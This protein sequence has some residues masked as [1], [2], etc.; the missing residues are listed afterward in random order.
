LRRN[1]P[2][3]M[4]ACCGKKKVV[5]IDTDGDGIPD[6]LDDDIDGDGIPNHLDD[7]ANGDGIPDVEQGYVLPTAPADPMGTPMHAGQIIQFEGKFFVAI[8]GRKAP[9]VWTPAAIPQPAK[10]L[11]KGKK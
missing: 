8:P 10:P 5:A 7:D 1:R 2:V 3:V 9:L 4:G 6:H 11:P